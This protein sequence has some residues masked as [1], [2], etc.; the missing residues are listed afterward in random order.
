MHR[1]LLTSANQTSL[2]KNPSA[3]ATALVVQSITVSQGIEHAEFLDANVACD[4]DDDCSDGSTSDYVSCGSEDE[5]D[6][7]QSAAEHQAREREKQMVL[8]AAG[9]IVNQN[10]KPPP[11]LSPKSTEKIAPVV[12]RRRSVRKSDPY[13]KDLPPL[14]DAEPMDHATRLDDALERFK[15]I[16]DWQLSNNRLSLISMESV[17]L[18]SPTISSTSSIPSSTARENE[19]QRKYSHFLQFLSGPKAHEPERRPIS[20]LTI[21]GPMNG[22]SNDISGSASPK[23]GTVCNPIFR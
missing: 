8:E 11:T 16:K 6:D 20:T 1:S 4:R 15:S 18:P 23:L 19:G 17:S 22:V 13:I 2:D 3:R 7:T 5:A 21:S 9:L 14:P 10:V 12:P